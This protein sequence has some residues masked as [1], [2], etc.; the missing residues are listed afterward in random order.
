MKY[1]F[2]HSIFLYGLFASI[3]RFVLTMSQ[4]NKYN[5]F[6]RLAQAF[7]QHKE[8]RNF[9]SFQNLKFMSEIEKIH[10]S[11][12]IN[13]ERQINLIIKKALPTFNFRMRSLISHTKNIFLKIIH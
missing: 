3:N 4:S 6:T 13:F 1:H 7:C 8:P 12:I 9:C 5:D 11:N 2:A 10:R